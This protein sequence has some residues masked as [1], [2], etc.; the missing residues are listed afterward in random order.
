MECIAAGKILVRGLLTKRCDCL[1]SQKLRFTTTFVQC[2][3]ERDNN[4]HTTNEGHNTTDQIYQAS[5]ERLVFSTLATTAAATTDR[6]VYPYSIH[7][8]NHLPNQQ[9]TFTRQK[10]FYCTTK[11]TRKKMV[12][13]IQFFYYYVES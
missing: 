7:W 13:I 1:R 10:R 2:D 9:S 5:C 4:K 8:K 6:P 3:E 11:V 12:K